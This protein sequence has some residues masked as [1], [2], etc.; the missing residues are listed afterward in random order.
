MKTSSK[1]L[2]VTAAVA[3]LLGACSK[4]A[5]V[6]SS[7]SEVEKAFQVSSASAAT[8]TPTTPTQVPPADAND[9]VKT[10]LSAARADDYATGVIALQAAQRQPG[11]TADQAIAAQNA[12]L[13]MTSALVSRAAKGDK[14]ALAQLKAIERT[15]SQ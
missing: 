14:A 12:M 11:V 15:H 10:A 2:L 6:K 13:A 5:D 4:K 1:L 9:L 8:P 3:L 7:V